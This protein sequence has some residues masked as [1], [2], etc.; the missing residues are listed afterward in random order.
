ML[1]LSFKVGTR[2]QQYSSTCDE[3]KAVYEFS[4]FLQAFV[5]LS[6]YNMCYVRVLTPIPMAAKSIAEMIAA[7]RRFKVSDKHSATMSTHKS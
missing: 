1:I 4:V 2:Q 3:K 7:M 5:V 6:I